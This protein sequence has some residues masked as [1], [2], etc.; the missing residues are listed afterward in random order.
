MLPA[1]MRPFPL[2]LDRAHGPQWLQMVP[3]CLD[4]LHEGIAAGIYVLRRLKFK[5]CGE[6]ALGL[7]S[8]VTLPRVPLACPKSRHSE[9]PSE[10][11][12]KLTQS[13][14]TASTCA[15]APV[16]P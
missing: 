4:E 3:T 11:T 12:K 9:A 1:W 16:P 2:H 5:R 7:S 6:L 14:G 13:D 8:R 10:T 15:T